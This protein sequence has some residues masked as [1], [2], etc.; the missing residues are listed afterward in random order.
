MATLY[1]HGEVLGDYTR[2]VAQRNGAKIGYIFRHMSDGWILVRPHRA[3]GRW[4]LFRR[5]D[6]LTNISMIVDCFLRKQLD[7]VFN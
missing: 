3:G 6:T 4:R 7:N 1:K 2:F 5:G